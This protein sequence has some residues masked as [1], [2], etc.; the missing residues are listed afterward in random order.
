[1]FVIGLFFNKRKQNIIVIVEV[2]FISLP[3]L[4]FLLSHQGNY[5]SEFSGWLSSSCFY[6]FLFLAAPCGMWDLSS[7]MR[8]PT[9]A[10]CIGRTESFFLMC[11]FIYLFLDDWVF[12]A[13]RGLS[14]VAVSGGYSWLWC[15]GATL[16]C[17][18]RA[19]HCSG[20]SCCGARALGTRALV[21]VARGL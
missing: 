2:P 21:L 4:I 5:Y 8:D 18:A 14:L 19:S 20:F 3:Y 10:P 9:Q 7:L 13:A 1:M 12:V 6:L 15:T 16:G 11:Y 17:G